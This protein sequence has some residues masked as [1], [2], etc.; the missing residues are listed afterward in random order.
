MQADRRTLLWVFAINAGFFVAES[1]AGWLARSMGLVADG[2]DMLADAFVYGLALAA[3][4][5]AAGH[6]RRVAHISGYIQLGLAVLGFG[7]VLR[8][9]ISGE[10]M[11]E[12]WTM[13]VVSL[14]ALAGNLAC[15][16]LLRKAKNGEAHMQASWIF[17]TTDAQVNVG[18]MVAAG[19][20]AFTGS[21]WPDLLIGTLVFGLVLRGAW[22]ILKL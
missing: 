21:R 6:K 2:L 13:V 11:P 22:R 12:P 20:V 1:L 4:G 18:V 9:A 8:R 15:L 16:Y 10:A 17:T 14:F 19:L 3:I 7:E 5:K